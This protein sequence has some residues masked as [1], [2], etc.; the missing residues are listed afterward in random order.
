MALEKQKDFIESMTDSK[1]TLKKPA[2]QTFGLAFGALL[3]GL[4]SLQGGVAQAAP[5]AVVE[6]F[7]SQGCSSC[8]PADAF[9]AEL[10][11]NPEII[12][13]TEAV[14]YWDYLG[15]KDANAR[16]EHTERQQNYARVRGDRRIYTPQ[17]VIN[18]RVH[19]VGSNRTS[20]KT[21]ISRLSGGEGKL[22]VPINVSVE[23]D[24]LKINVDASS[25][26]GDLKDGTLYLALYEKSVV[27]DIKRGENRG[28]SVTYH[29]VVRDI[30]SVGMWHGD[31]VS[32]EL[33][34]SEIRNSGYDGAAVFLQA[35]IRGLPGPIFGA[36]NVALK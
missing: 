22:T 6:L 21:H 16:H 28:R 36:Q 29:N 14:D 20:V 10:A 24:S 13:L 30:R 3:L 11:E 8:P 5:V 4:S 15:W 33:P 27:A 1:L 19:A 35:D 12:A 7:T 32:I 18:G 25:V 23:A 9:L 26:S 17:M 2:R 34:M 31:A